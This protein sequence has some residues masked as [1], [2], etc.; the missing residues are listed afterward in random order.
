MNGP[1]AVRCMLATLLLS[2]ASPCFAGTT[3][4]STNKPPNIDNPKKLDDFSIRGT[5]FTLKSLAE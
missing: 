2:I 5:T 1:Y 3:S 4:A